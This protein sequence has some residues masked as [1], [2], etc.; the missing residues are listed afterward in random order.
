LLFFTLLSKL[1]PNALLLL[2]LL[3][4]LLFYYT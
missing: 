1:F 3:L 2:L 4:L